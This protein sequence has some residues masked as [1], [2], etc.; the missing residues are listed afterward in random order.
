MV[1]DNTGL[2]PN[3]RSEY[4]RYRHKVRQVFIRMVLVMDTDTRKILAF[5]VTDNTVSEATQFEPLVCTALGNASA[6]VTDVFADGPDPLRQL[7]S[8]PPP[9][10]NREE[11]DRFR[12]IIMR[13]NSRFDSRK[14]FEIGRQLGIT[15]YIRISHNAT[16][17]SR[18]VSRARAIAVIDHWEAALQIRQSVRG[19]LE[20]ARPTVESG[21]GTR[22][23]GDGC[24]R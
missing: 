23:T 14:I 13:A 2:N 12:E 8:P 7:S 16:M 21:K 18:G 6:N 3:A 10:T 24:P 5:S 11:L 19:R 20:S 22:R 17:R 9:P 4:I 15:P 1:I